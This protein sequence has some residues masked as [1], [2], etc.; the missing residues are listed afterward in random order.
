[1]TL[2][3]EDRHLYGIAGAACSVCCAAPLLT[4]LGVAGAAA[5][6]A[7]FVIAGIVFGSVVAGATVLARWRRRRRSACST[8]GGPN[9]GP[10]DLE[11]TADGG[12]RS[13]VYPGSA[14]DA[15]TVTVE[16]RT[17]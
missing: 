3:L 9:G 11:I 6:V 14:P 1:M 15:D 8:R 5:F 7:I 17:R 10:V 16:R 12:R 13:G 2:S 4:L